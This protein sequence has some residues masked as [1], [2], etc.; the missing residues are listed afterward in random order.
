MAIDHASA[1]SPQHE[2]DALTSLLSQYLDAV[3]V[4]VRSRAELFSLEAQRAAASATRLAMLGG[5]LL[6]VGMTAWLLLVTAVVL[7]LAAAG[8]PLLAALLI[9]FALHLIAAFVTIGRMRR[10]TADF[11]FGATRRSLR[12]GIVKFRP[13]EGASAGV[14]PIAVPGTPGDVAAGRVATAAAG[15]ATAPAAPTAEESHAQK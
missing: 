12:D 8:M 7:G 14:P 6:I 11:E 4:A 15:P 13:A 3:R 1:R 10:M 2:H 9:V 5:V